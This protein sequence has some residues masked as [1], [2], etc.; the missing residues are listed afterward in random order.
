MSKA[1]RGQTKARELL[2]S[3]YKNGSKL[4]QENGKEI[5]KYKYVYNQLRIAYPFLKGNEPGNKFFPAV[6]RYYLNNDLKDNE[7]SS[8]FNKIM[9]LLIEGHINE[10]DQDLNGLSIHEILTRF[11]QTVQS[12]LEDDY[13]KI[14]SVKRVKNMNYDIIP[15]DSAQD[16]QKYADATAWCIISSE[17]ALK[18]YNYN[19]CGQFYIC[20]H[21]DYKK[22]K[23]VKG[24]NAPLDK[25][26]LSMLAICVDIPSI[27]DNIAGLK[28]C[29]CRWNHTNGGNDNVMTTEQISDL[30]GVNFYETFKPNMKWINIV[31]DITTKL[32][33]TEIPL[34]EIFKEG[35]VEETE[36][37]YSSV[38]INSK[39]NFVNKDRKLV[40]KI[41]YDSVHKFS[42]GYASVCLKDRGWN[43]IDTEGNLVFDKWYKT[44]EPFSDGYAGV[45]VENGK[46]NYIDL[47]GNFIS[48]T[49]FKSVQPFS[50]GYGAVELEESKYNFI[51]KNGKF[52]C[53]THFNK[54]SSFSGGYAAIYEKGKGWNYI[55]KKGKNISKQY[56]HRV[57]SFDN[58]LAAIYSEDK[59]WNYMDTKGN[60]LSDTFFSSMI[61]NTF[62]WY[63]VYIKDKGGNYINKNGE[64]L[65]DKWFSEINNFHTNGV[66][67][68]KTHDGKEFNLDIKGK[69]VEIGK[70]N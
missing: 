3:Y 10:Y 16:L 13:K 45:E 26:G 34:G 15:I 8:C 19:G 1:S 42:D 46:W 29:T 36:T 11:E 65:S 24:K 40:S 44:I 23:N 68:V 7:I 9:P 30:L 56:W 41:W 53:K 2:K 5:E 50:D 60:L 27:N 58:G 20:V 38:S 12:V 63:G 67:R 39:Y 35:S 43:L 18:R 17:S 31:R 57:Y 49:H 54:I 61:F 59:G 22:I 33:S 37:G 14:S 4:T 32:N 25:Y 69:L 21:K 28:S 6:V 52:L 62:G 51:G 66:A 70:K 47:E 48:D 55:N 64:Y